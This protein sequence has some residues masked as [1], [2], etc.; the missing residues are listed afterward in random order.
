MIS[1][2]QVITEVV[3]SLI[4]ININVDEEIREILKNELSNIKELEKDIISQILENHE[5]AKTK[6]IPLCQDT[7]IIV[8]NI[9]IGQDS[10]FDFNIEEALNEAIEIA[11]TDFRKSVVSH[12]LQRE[13]T[14]TNTP[15]IF[16][17][18]MVKGEKLIIQMS[19]KGAG[20]ENMSKQAMLTPAHGF[21]GVV[22]F[23][24]D[25]VVNAKGNPCPP[26]I[27]GVGIGGNFEYSAVL[28]KRALYRPIEDCAQV[29]I[30]RKLENILLEKINE[31][32][33][34][35]M[36]IGGKLTALSVKVNSYPCHIASLPVAVNIQC[37]VSRH[38]EVIL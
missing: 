23:V 20:S 9:K 6:Q 18:E 14:K 36:G 4:D 13:N 28:A 2:Q 25:T 11:Y 38:A 5:I 32:K 21:D 17:Y 16:H 8:F 15:G 37:H 7:G 24:I 29:E 33:I 3:K 10:K 35:A 31:T 22:D 19:A 1:R 27:V 34:G 12:P 30:D 26:I